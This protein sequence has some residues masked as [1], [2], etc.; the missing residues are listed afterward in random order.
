MAKTICSNFISKFKIGDNIE[1]NLSVLGE[2][3]KSQSALL[4]KPKIIQIASIAEV[5]VYDFIYGRLKRN[6]SKDEVDVFLD[7]ETLKAI[8]YDK[9]KPKENSSGRISFLK[10][11]IPDLREPIQDI[12]GGSHFFVS[13]EYLI[14]LRNRIHIE[15]KHNNQ[16]PDEEETFTETSLKRG[17]QTLEY[18]MSY[19]S[20]HYRGGKY[21]HVNN[22]ILPWK[23][24]F[25]GYPNYSGPHF[26]LY[27][28]SVGMDYRRL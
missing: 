12:H 9:K 21:H 11:Y 20:I 18:L 22:F 17:E 5:C 16:L 24:Y 7:A 15:N 14:K 6:P 8:R 19:L 1:Y 28:G 4:I 23:P 25:L 10:K 3:Y 26:N 2:L 27:K 13:L